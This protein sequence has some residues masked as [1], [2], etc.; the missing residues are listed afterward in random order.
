MLMKKLVIV[1]VQE[2]LKWYS[3]SAIENR[4]ALYLL[5]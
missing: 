2:K 4:P 5:Q 3:T 1:L